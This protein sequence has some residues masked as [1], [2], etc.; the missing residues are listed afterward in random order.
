MDNETIEMDLIEIT[1]DANRTIKVINV[2]Q[3][4]F[5]K[6]FYFEPRQ[7]EIYEINFVTFENGIMYK[8]YF[9]NK[10][11]SKFMKLITK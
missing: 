5:T 11:H 6:E 2:Y 9:S 4:Y 8:C 3:D 1:V 10:Y 7:N